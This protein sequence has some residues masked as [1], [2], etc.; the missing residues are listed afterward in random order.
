[1]PN[2]L[3]GYG[4]RAHRFCNVNEHFAISQE[5]NKRAK[6][7]SEVEQ[8]VTIRDPVVVASAHPVFC[9]KFTVVHDDRTL[10]CHGNVAGHTET[11]S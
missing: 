10:M 9:W 11:S 5:G 4:T 6:V 2:V 8:H 1:M 3:R 7:Q